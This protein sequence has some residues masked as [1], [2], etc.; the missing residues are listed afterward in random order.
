M[1]DTDRYVISKLESMAQKAHDDL[2][3]DTMSAI[4]TSID[5]MRQL[6]SIKE[7]VNTQLIAGKNHYKETHECFLKIA[8]VIV[9]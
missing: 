4:S 6:D 9:S 2:D 8:N 5:Q 7:I 1:T 3:Y